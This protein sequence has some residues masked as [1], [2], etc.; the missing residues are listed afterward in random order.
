MRGFIVAMVVF[1][2]VL[3]GCS[4]PPAPYLSSSGCYFGRVVA[5]RS[6]TGGT[7]TAQITQILGWPEN[8][9]LITGQE[10]VIRLTDGEVKVLVPPQ[11]A[12][13]AGLVP[14]DDVMITEAP[15]LQI[16]LQ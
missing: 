3:T 6:V 14:G 10:I 8:I 5:I 4:G 9:P 16:S 2:G 12:I 7:L 13:P 15:R 1:L 11:Q